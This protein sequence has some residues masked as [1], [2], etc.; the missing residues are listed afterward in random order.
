MARDFLEATT[1]TGGKGDGWDAFPLASG[2]PWW[3]KGATLV[4]DETG[5]DAHPLYAGG[6]EP[7]K[8]LGEQSWP[9]LRQPPATAPLATPD[10]AALARQITV[11]IVCR[12]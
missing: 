4:P 7:G 12:Q 1:R 10:L 3:T 9:V 5:A 11:Q 2:K 8:Q 6:G